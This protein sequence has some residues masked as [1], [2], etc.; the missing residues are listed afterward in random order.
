MNIREATIC[1]MEAVYLM[2]YDAW[3]DNRQINEYLDMCRQSTKYQRGQWFVLECS[4]TGNLLSSLIVYDLTQ[5]EGRIHKGIGSIAT[6]PPERCKGLAAT[7]L[8][9][10][11]ERMESAHQDALFFLYSDIGTDYYCKLGFKVLDDH[12][13][14]Y[15]SHICMWYSSNDHLDFMTKEIPDYF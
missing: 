9:G 3:G 12:N 5:Q 11:M 7:L 4:E 8:K 13:Q 15:K 2:G 1:D 10:V 6:A 14:K